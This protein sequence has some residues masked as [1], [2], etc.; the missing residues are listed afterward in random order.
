M[1][2]G[3]IAPVV[4]TAH[5][6]CPLCEA[7]CGLEI[8]LDAE[9]TVVRIRGDRDDVFSQGFICPKGSTLKQLHEDPDRLRTPM[10]RIDGRHVPVSWDDAWGLVADGFSRVVAAHGRG[11]LG[12]YLGNPGAHSLALMAYNRIVLQAMGTRQIFSA[13]SVDQMPK[14]VA[15]GLMFGTPTSVPV[16]DLDRTDHLFMLGANP[17]ASNGSLCTAPDFP[18]R[19]RA[20]RDRGGRIVVVDPRRTKSAEAADEWVPIRPGTDALLLAAMVHVMFADALVRLPEHLGDAVAGLDDLRA[21][22][23]RFTP[24]NVS[25]ATGVDADT[26]VRLTRE[27][28]AARTAAMYGRIGVNTVSFGS[29]SAWLVDVMN[30]IS[31]NLDRPGGAMFTLPAVGGPTVRGTPRVGKGFRTGRGYSRVRGFPEVMGEYPVVTMAEEILEPGNGR[32]RG[33]LTVAGNPILSTPNDGGL[34]RAFESLEFMVSVDI[35]L[36]ETTRH[37]DVILPP[38]S[39]LQRDHYDLSLYTFAVRNVANYSPPVLPL[40]P[41]QPDE[42][43]IMAK[44]AGIFQAFDPGVDPRVVDDFAVD[45]LVRSAV[46]DESSPAAGRDPEEVLARLADSGRRGP[47]RLLDVMLQSGP[48]GA[49]FGAREEGL[50][51]DVLLANPHGVD[52]GPLASR[53]PGML[54]TASGMI[55]LAPSPFVEDLD[56]LEEH[57]TTMSGAGDGRLSLIGRRHLKSN[58][59][60]MHN[61]AVLTKG[62][63]SCT[64]QI[65]PDDASAR[66]IADGDEVTVR[67]DVGEVRTVAEVTD[68]VMSGVVSLPHGWGHGEPGTTMSVAAAKPGVNSNRLASSDALDPLSGNA[69]LN[70]IAVDVTKVG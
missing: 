37:A 63:L 42:W 53:M 65:N 55:E 69:V 3:N 26:I 45:Q 13:S 49:G 5:R 47:A 20:I 56:R 27:F 48:Y 24:G 58:N 21:A 23:S 12:A 22:T 64:L 2:R 34:D 44:L 66:G 10:A 30:T 18:G 28:A 46:R 1:S 38:P 16:P 15:G 14:H 40:E 29:T 7:T 41:G 60:W 6:T 51:M 17:H 36:N 68:T 9:G 70:A 35:Y 33:M 62:S 8:G 67:S 57:R 19:M 59:S 31:G 4:R 39:Q 11:A 43:E 54:R 50:S 25:S 32:I 61:I 52:L